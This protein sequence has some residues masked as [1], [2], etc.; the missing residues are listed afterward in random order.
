MVPTSTPLFFFC[1]AL[2]DPE[3]ESGM[4]MMVSWELSG[5]GVVELSWVGGGGDGGGGSGG[6]GAGGGWREGR[7]NGPAE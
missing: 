2:G 3:A 6:L 5:D 4:V 1:R 7:D